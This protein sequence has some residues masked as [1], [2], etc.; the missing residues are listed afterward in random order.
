MRAL[1]RAGMKH[2]A[3]RLVAD[4]LV[5]ANLCGHEFSSLP[6]VIA[7][8]DELAKKPTPP[9]E[10]RVVRE[11]R[12]TA[13]IDGGD[14]VAYV[15]SI[16]GIDKAVPEKTTE[17]KKPLSFL[18]EILDRRGIII[19]IS[20]F[21]DEPANILAGLKALKAKGNDIMTFH[22]MD[23]YELTFPFEEMAQFEDLETTEKMHVIPEYLRTQY[24]KV[25]SDHIELL[26]KGLKSAQ[27]DY[28][29][30]NTSQP[31]DSALFTYLAARARTI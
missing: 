13:L 7:I 9:G 24:L 1:T 3:A 21:Y 16:H 20:D 11:D 15:A 8:V 31:L 22:I 26:K 10:I 19:L 28:T 23:D 30:M 29:L 12:S 4:H 17:F 14:N 6:R 2:E 18:A 25:M 5:D 27:I